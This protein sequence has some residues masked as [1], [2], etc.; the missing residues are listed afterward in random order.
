[1]KLEFDDLKI[2]EAKMLLDCLVA[3]R[4]G[5]PFSWAPHLVNRVAQAETNERNGAAKRD[6]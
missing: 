3:F 2:V 1:M 5:Q 4:A 6:G